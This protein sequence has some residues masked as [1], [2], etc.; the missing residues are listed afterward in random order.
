M[1]REVK[2]I[3]KLARKF[4]RRREVRKRTEKRRAEVVSVIVVITGNSINSVIITT[5][6]RMA[7]YC[8]V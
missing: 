4:W 3:R 1:S 2:K 7:V 5:I 6:K 8:Q